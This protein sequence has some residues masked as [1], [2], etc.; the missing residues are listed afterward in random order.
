MAA[1]EMALAGKMAGAGIG[2]AIKSAAVNSTTAKGAIISSG[3]AKTA[4]GGALFTSKGVGIGL[5]F[6]AVGP[7]VVGFTVSALVIGL[8][9]KV[10][11]GIK[12]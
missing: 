10:H 3:V 11:H 8:Y 4:L 9:L 6:A 7:L 1:L 5:G 2:T 12:L